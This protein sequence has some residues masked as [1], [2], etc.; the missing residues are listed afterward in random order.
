MPVILPDGIPQ[1]MFLCKTVTLVSGIRQILLPEFGITATIDLS[2]NTLGLQNKYA[3]AGDYNMVD[4]CSVISVTN[5]KIIVNPVVLAVQVLQERRNSLLA[6]IANCLCTTAIFGCKQR[7]PES[8]ILLNCTARELCL[9]V[10][11]A[12]LFTLYALYD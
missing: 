9:A 6:I 12:E 7:C 5:Q 10:L 8:F 2:M 4:L 11:L 3:V 1:L